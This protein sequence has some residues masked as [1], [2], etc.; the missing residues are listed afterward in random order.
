MSWSEWML[1]Y[2]AVGALIVILRA[3]NQGAMRDATDLLSA[4]FAW[5]VT[6]ASYPPY[7][8]KRWRNERARQARITAD[9]AS[10]ETDATWARESLRWRGP[11]GKEKL[12]PRDLL[13]KTSTDF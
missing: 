1:V 13:Q 4:V 10:G 3:V 12:P 8:F 9:V 11:S 5:P 7:R 2:I 6:L